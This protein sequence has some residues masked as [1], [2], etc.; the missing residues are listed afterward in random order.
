MRGEW[1]G[2]EEPRRKVGVGGCLVRKAQSRGEWPGDRITF[3]RFWLV[4]VLEAEGGGRVDVER[5]DEVGRRRDCWEV[6]VGGGRRVVLVGIFGF[7]V[8]VDV[9]VDEVAGMFRRSW[10]EGVA[11]GGRDRGVDGGGGGG[12]IMRLLL[13]LLGLILIGGT[14]D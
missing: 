4:V 8:D 9:K 12:S 5:E 6:V 3:F 13:L 11:A 2:T 1:G 7:G 10:G 14:A